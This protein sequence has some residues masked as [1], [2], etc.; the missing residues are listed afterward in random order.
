MDRLCG[1]TFQG[2]IYFSVI[3]RRCCNPQCL[4]EL[5]KRTGFFI[6]EST[7][8]QCQAWFI[9]STLEFLELTYLRAYPSSYLPIRLPEKVQRVRQIPQIYIEQLRNNVFV[10]AKTEVSSCITN[11]YEAAIT[12]ITR[13]LRWKLITAASSSP[14]GH[15]PVCAP[16]P[17]T[18]N[19]QV[20]PF[21]APRTRA[22]PSKAKGWAEGLNS[23]LR[24]SISYLITFSTV[25]PRSS[26]QSR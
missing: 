6:C 3:E 12:L 14:W 26:K 21:R 10:I 25:N 15:V 8:L 1:R 4:I 5:I 17:Y 7:A 13:L 16:P 20:E 24:N 9:I 19:K 22:S 23:R 18:R 11:A 2:C